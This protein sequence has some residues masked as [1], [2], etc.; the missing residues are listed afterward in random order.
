MLLVPDPGGLAPRIRC[1][2]N[3]VFLAAQAHA[4][5]ELLAELPDLLVG[6]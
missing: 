4:I 5:F 6:I 2:D 3:L 1:R